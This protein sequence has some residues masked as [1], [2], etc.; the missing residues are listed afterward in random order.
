[1]ITIPESYNES[2][3][4][5][6]ARLS[7][8]QIR[9]PSACHTSLP[10][11]GSPHLSTDILTTEPLAAKDRL[12]V[13]STG[14][15]GIEGYLGSAVLELFFEEY[16]LHLNPQSTG[17][18]LIH[19]IN[20]WGMENRERNNSANVDLNRNF[21]S[22]EFSALADFNIDYP[23]LSPYFNPRGSLRH[24]ASAR[25]GFIASTVKN[26]IVFNSRRMREAALMGQYRFQGGIYFG[27]R[28]IQ[29]ETEAMM[30]VFRGA[31]AGYKEIIHLDMHTGYGPRKQMTLVTSPQEK[32]P[33]AE[34]S[35]RYGAPRV[36]AINP[37]EFYT[38]QGDMIDW[39]YDLIRKEF[40][41]VKFFGAACEFGTFG[42]SILQAARS[43]QITIFKNQVRRHGAD[44]QAAAW[45]AREYCELYL[46]SEPAW[47]EKALADARMTFD[48]VV[49]ERG[50]FT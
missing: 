24:L 18:L 10:L 25:L 31:F 27:G 5:F 15:H 8:L 41:D 47:L 20:P 36:A 14:E 4:R 9:W 34:I 7:T 35:A 17:L 6:Q 33:A 19:A 46:P 40:P 42:D 2:R 37:D 44:P 1:M 45:V 38:I 48:A 22:T 3:A 28:Q 43:L 29:S 13:L 32:T 11:P 12:I 49:G 23:A 21:V 50:F 30:K 26:F 16:A 39:E